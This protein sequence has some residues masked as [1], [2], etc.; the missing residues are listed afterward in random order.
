M[1]WHKITVKTT[2]NGINEKRSAVTIPLVIRRITKV[3]TS[4]AQSRTNT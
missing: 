2:I 4:I 3:K 1:K